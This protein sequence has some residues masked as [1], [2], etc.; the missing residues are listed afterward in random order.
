MRIALMKRS[1]KKPEG[2]VVEILARARDTFIGTLEPIG[3]RLFFIPDQKNAAVDFI[4]PQDK[5]G[6]GKKVKRWLSG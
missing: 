5:A 6:E 2:R 1:R 3:G 4:I